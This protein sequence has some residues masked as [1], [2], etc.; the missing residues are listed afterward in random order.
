[1]DI[2]QIEIWV[3]IL[4]FL[5]LILILKY[6]QKYK[7]NLL[8]SWLIYAFGFELINMH[9]TDHYTYYNYEI[10]ILWLPLYVP[11]VWSMM[12]THADILIKSYTEKLSIKNTIFTSFLA[13]L[14]ILSIDFIVDVVAV[15]MWA[16]SR[17]LLTSQW[18]YWVSYWNF[19]WRFIVVF[20][21]FLFWQNVYTRYKHSIYRI[22]AVIVSSLFTQTAII[23]LPQY[24]VSNNNYNEQ[25]YFPEFV[26]IQIAICLIV[27]YGFIWKYKTISKSLVIS[28]V[29]FVFFIW[30]V[31]TICWRYIYTNWLPY[32]IFITFAILC[33]L[34]CIEIFIVLYKY[35]NRI[36]K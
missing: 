30:C 8:I 20:I 4:W 23:V 17:N 25:V 13:W 16:W 3:L 9:W 10:W 6:K 22:F 19:F 18:W 32:D 7:F 11:L 26:Y 35:W 34:Y 1:M 12:I 21:F 28:D 5:Y 15:D 14:Y 36:I 31:H 29:I 33:L 2:I 24:L 27:I